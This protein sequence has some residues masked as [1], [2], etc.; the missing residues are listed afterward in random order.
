MIRVSTSNLAVI[1]RLCGEGLDKSQQG[2][3]KR[4]EG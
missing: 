4:K 3:D 1:G 2:Q